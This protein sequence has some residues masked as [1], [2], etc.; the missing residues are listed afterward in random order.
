ME[1][2]STAVVA[3]ALNTDASKKLLGP[4]IE[5]VGSEIKNLVERCNINIEDIFTKATY[6]AEHKLDSEGQVSP[7]VLRRVLTDGAFCNSEVVRDYYA[8]ILAASRTENIEDDRGVMFM[9]ILSSLTTSQVKL[10]QL[11]FSSILKTFTL[12]DYISEDN[13]GIFIPNNLFEITG[14]KEYWMEHALE[15]LVRQRIIES[16][17]SVNQ[18]IIKLKEYN[19]N[20]NEPGF[21]VSPLTTGAELFMWSLGKEDIS[22]NEY[23]EFSDIETINPQGCLKIT[24]DI[25]LKSYQEATIETA[26]HSVPVPIYH[27][28]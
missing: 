5:Y 20:I 26:I 16:E 27:S 21:I 23:F 28:R 18:P 1:P 3:Y 14:N 7:R 2:I 11:I 24:E 8:G 19:K 6:K 9:D 17:Y 15:G 13:H 22:F 10:H 25:I 12:K 4:T